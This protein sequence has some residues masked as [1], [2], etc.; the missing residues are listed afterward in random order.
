M[1]QLQRR[2]DKK[3]RHRERIEDFELAVFQS[4]N[5]NELDKAYRLL[6]GQGSS[7]LR[8]V[9]LDIGP[10]RLVSLALRG[11]EL[12]NAETRRRSNQFLIEILTV[13]E[14]AKDPAN[15]AYVEE[16]WLLLAGQRSILLETIE[17]DLDALSDSALSKRDTNTRQSELLRLHRAIRTR[18]EA[19]IQSLFPLS[20][21]TLSP[22]AH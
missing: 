21:T 7:E 1:D 3:T 2:T 16:M 14:S 13:I 5:V 8:A 11:Y 22:L 19:L 18:S 10:A 9:S 17:C 4:T 20:Q 6:T 12:P 15:R